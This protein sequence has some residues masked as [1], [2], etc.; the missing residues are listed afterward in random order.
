MRWR[1]TEESEDK[2]AQSRRFWIIMAM[3]GVVDKKQRFVMI[4]TLQLCEADAVRLRSAVEEDMAESGE[5]L[6]CEVVALRADDRTPSARRSR[7]SST[8]WCDIGNNHRRSGSR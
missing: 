3:S 6:R 4:L 2:H 8:S 1:P 7:P 5:T